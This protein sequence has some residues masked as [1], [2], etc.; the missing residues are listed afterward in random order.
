[1]V[2]QEMMV[3]NYSVLYRV[4]ANPKKLVARSKQSISQMN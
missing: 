3:V 4:M 2:E 1:M